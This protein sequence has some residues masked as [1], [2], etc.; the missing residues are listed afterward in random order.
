MS[1]GRRDD[2]WPG[3]CPGSRSARAGVAADLAPALAWLA[4]D[5]AAFVT[6]QDLAVDGRHHDGP[7][8]LGISRRPRRSGPGHDPGHGSG[9]KAV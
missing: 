9:L 5:A 8:G 4:S 1:G 2:G 7:P 3:S 6:G